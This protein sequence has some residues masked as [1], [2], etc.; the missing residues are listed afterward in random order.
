MLCPL[1]QYREVREK[2]G[3]CPKG[4]RGIFCFSSR[5]EGARPHIDV[6][7]DDLRN[8]FSLGDGEKGKKGKNEGEAK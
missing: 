6:I 7:N 1:L 4:D 2:G 8:A 3:Y 5:K